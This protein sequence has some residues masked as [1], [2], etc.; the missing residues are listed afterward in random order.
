MLTKITQDGENWL[1]QNLGIDIEE[2]DRED[3]VS[4]HSNSVDN[5]ISKKDFNTTNWFND[6]DKKKKNVAVR[7]EELGLTPQTLEALYFHKNMII[8][9]MKRRDKNLTGILKKM[10]IV[11]IFTRANISDEI[12]TKIVYDV[13]NIYSNL[14][15]LDYIK[16][17][18]GLLK[19]IRSINIIN[20]LF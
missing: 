18:A 10:D 12:T 8:A 3:A 11:E 6:A 13:L 1:K 7:L 15:A 4:V 19:D 16:F 17:M 20:L 9:E 2:L 5:R 14:N